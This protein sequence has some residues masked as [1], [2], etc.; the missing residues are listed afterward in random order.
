[1]KLYSVDKSCDF[2]NF[3]L[4]VK[5]LEAIESEVHHEIENV[6]NIA[7]DHDHVTENAPDRETETE[8]ATKIEKENQIAIVTYD[9]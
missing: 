3:N 7:Q 1:M 8:S 4:G 9:S 5:N 2:K 6:R